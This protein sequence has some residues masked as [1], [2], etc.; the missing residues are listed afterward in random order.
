MLWGLRQPSIFTI[1]LL[2][3]VVFFSFWIRHFCKL[4]T[5]AEKPSNVNTSADVRIA[6][7]SAYNAKD[8]VERITVQD[9]RSVEIAFSTFKLIFGKCMN[10]QK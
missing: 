7:D 8:M 2:T 6:V 4:F 10:A 5:N 3:C 9:R 1:V